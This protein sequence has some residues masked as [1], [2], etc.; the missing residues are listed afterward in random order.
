MLR[1]R[2]KAVTKP[3]SGRDEAERRYCQARGIA[4]ATM[5]SKI[6]LN[7]RAH[8]DLLRFTGQL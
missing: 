7:V 8:G 5:I 2:N 6:L 3:S 1:Y 4:A